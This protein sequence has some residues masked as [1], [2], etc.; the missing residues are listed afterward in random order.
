M[1]VTDREFAGPSP[2]MGDSSTYLGDDHKTSVGSIHSRS[3]V[4]P[5]RLP[6]S[7]DS[8]AF[9]SLV[10]V[11]FR[12]GLAPYYVLEYSSSPRLLVVPVSCPSGNGFHS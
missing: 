6:C 11:A 8:Y 5:V 4:D 12:W 2:E 9:V 1:K 3:L 7:G 10:R